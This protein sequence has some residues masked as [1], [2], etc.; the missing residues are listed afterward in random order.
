[1]N[2]MK[3]IALIL[4]VLIS[5]CSDGMTLAPIPDA[6]ASPGATEQ[7]PAPGLTPAPDGAPPGAN[8]LPDG[9]QCGNKPGVPYN[10]ELCS[11]CMALVVM[12][13]INDGR[14]P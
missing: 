9:C 3:P 11:L 2:T 13:K 4:A 12:V 10:A 5:G 8:A 14:V 1:M 6:G 7:Q